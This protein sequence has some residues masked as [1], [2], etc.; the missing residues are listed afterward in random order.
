MPTATWCGATPRRPDLNCRRRA[1][2]RPADPGRS[3][4]SGYFSPMSPAAGLLEWLARP[5]TLARAQGGFNVIAGAWPLLSVRTFEAI[6]GPKADR[7]LEYTVAGLL[8]VNGVEQ[9]LSSH[10]DDHATARGLG[11]GTAA[12]LAAVDA[13][14]VPT[15]RIPRTYAIDAAFEVAWMLL[16]IRSART[17]DGSATTVGAGR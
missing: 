12:T 9:L 13:V 5:Q 7:W 2:P 16:W 17:A 6:F 4:P 3:P 11:M 14:Y 8:L 15:G 10:R 1:D